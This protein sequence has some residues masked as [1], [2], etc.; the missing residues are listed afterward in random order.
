MR[1][2]PKAFLAGR[3]YLQNVG[4]RFFGRQGTRGDS[5]KRAFSDGAVGSSLF[6][7]P[8]QPFSDSPSLFDGTM[9]F[10]P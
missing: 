4:M 1:G 6:V 9:F 3:G 8:L 5:D 7:V 10:H 2:L